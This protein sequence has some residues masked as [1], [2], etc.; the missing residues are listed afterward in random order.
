MRL[1]RSLRTLDR[2]SAAPQRLSV[3]RFWRTRKFRR[4][5][6]HQFRVY[7]TRLAFGWFQPARY[8][9][10]S[11][12]A[13]RY[14]LSREHVVPS[15]KTVRYTPNPWFVANLEPLSPAGSESGINRVSYGR[16]HFSTP[17]AT[18]YVLSVGPR[19]RRPVGSQVQVVQVHTRAD[20]RSFVEFPYQHYRSDPH[21]VAPLRRD[22]K[23]ILNASEHPFY[24]HADLQCFL[25]L[26]DGEVRG[27]IAGI[28]DR[29][30]NAARCENVGTFGFFES[31][32][33]E[34]AARALLGAVAAWHQA[35]G[36]ETLRG[37]LSPSINYES[38]AL[39]EGFDSSPCVMM[40]YNPPYYDRLFK[41]MGLQKAMDLYAYRLRVEDVRCAPLNRARRVRS[42]DVEIRLA[43]RD[44]F[45]EEIE[46]IGRLFNQVWRQNW[47]AAPLSREEMRHLA[48]RLKPLLDP[49]LVLFA[50]V[51][52]HPIGF[53]MAVP[54][55]N[56]ALKSAKGSLFPF[57]LIKILAAKR[58]IRTLRV[59]ALGVAEP[60]RRSGVAAQLYLQLTQRAHHLGH[61]D[62]ECS[63]V[64]ESN[65][66]MNRSLGIMGADRY[67]TYRIY[68]RRVAD[69]LASIKTE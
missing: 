64:L 46:S 21:W 22:Q 43:R 42:A 17:C 6:Q 61:I 59:L 55:I 60:Y 41:S 35:R 34:P 53:A 5:G 62:A 49:E 57:G 44:R 18:F 23:H 28:V 27:R 54:D 2:N 50:E 47:G 3:A 16:N 24:A 1:G 36:V 52:G 19:H 13:R 10:V 56:R 4:T 12:A 11:S 33:S 7:V 67:K 32:D 26:S 38:G 29:A 58:N 30:Y 15:R 48:R 51:A 66:N 68:E 14:R 20:M 31:I 45:E 9:S 65:R 39:V 69:L 40:T 63:W 37:P 25:A 8:D